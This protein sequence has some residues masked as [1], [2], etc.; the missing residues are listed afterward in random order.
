MSVFQPTD[1]WPTAL[2]AL[3]YV[4]IE[5]NTENVSGRIRSS[6]RFPFRRLLRPDPMPHQAIDPFSRMQTSRAKRETSGMTAVRLARGH[7]I[8]PAADA[9]RAHHRVASGLVTVEVVLSPGRRQILS[10]N[11]PGDTFILSQEAGLDGLQARAILPSAVWLCP[12]DP[13]LPGCDC[14]LAHLASHRDNAAPWQL[15]QHSIML[16]RLTADE[17]VATFLLEQ[18]HRAQVGEGHSMRLLLPMTRQDMADYLGLNAD[19]LSRVL[20]RFQANGIISLHGR[21]GVDVQLL[22][23]LEDLSPFAAMLK[24]LANTVLVVA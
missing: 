5:I 10:F 8:Q 24:R 4:L 9:K 2:R 1:Q 19:T 15:W 18:M 7:T 22:R 14:P 3:N 17:R 12:P 20:A 23:E 11:R 21:S 13:G 16:G 6:R